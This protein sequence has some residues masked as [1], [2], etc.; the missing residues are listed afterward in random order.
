MALATVADLA[1][2]RIIK[3]SV[4]Q[5]IDD[6]PFQTIESLAEFVESCGLVVT[7][8]ARRS[9][10]MRYASGGALLRHWFI[11]IG[12][13]PAWRDVVA[14]ADR[15]DVFARLEADLDQLAHRRGRLELTIPLAFV[16]ARPG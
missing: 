4:L 8:T 9:E 11:K 7:R 13:L 12:F 10:T 3:E 14:A 6:Q 5:A 16:E 1:V 15:R 2:D